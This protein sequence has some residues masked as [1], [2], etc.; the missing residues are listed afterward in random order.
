MLHPDN[1]ALLPPPGS[2]V[3]LVVLAQARGPAFDACL[4][5]GLGGSHVPGAEYNILWVLCVEWLDGI[6][7]RRA[8]GQVMTSALRGAL[9]P[10]PAVTRILLG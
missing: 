6:A 5:A 1:I 9:A 8:V 7:E 2:A 3:D 10:G 4:D